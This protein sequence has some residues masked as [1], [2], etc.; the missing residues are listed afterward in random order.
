MNFVDSKIKQKRPLKNCLSKRRMI[1][2]NLFDFEF[3]IFDIDGTIID[4]MT[5]YEEIFATVLNKKT[6]IPKEE[7]KRFYQET[8][9]IVI[10][11]QFEQILAL[12]KKSADVS[13]MAELFFEKAGKKRF[14]AFPGAKKLLENLHKG[15]IKLFGTSGSRNQDLDKKLKDNGLL[16]YFDLIMGSSEI[17]KGIEH[18]KIF[19]DFCNIP[20]EKFAKKAFLIGDGP[21][22]MRIAKEAGI[23]AI[24]VSTT[25]DAKMLLQA[26]ANEVVKKIGV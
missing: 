26:D 23:Y 19:A 16:I 21:P 1:K 6:G 7:A 11:K 3:G 17:S 2:A 9:G 18:I 14:K 4:S 22:D 13:E 10:R 20:L 15:G 5:T 8:A 24:G 25:V 12:F